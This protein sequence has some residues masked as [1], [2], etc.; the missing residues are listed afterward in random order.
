[1]KADSWKNLVYSTWKKSSGDEPI[2]LCV[3]YA[4]VSSCQE[5]LLDTQYPPY[6][7]ERS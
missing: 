2:F 6:I 1:M 5:I 3:F 4:C 7:I